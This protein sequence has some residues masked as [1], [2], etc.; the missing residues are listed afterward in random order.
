[1]GLSTT[2]DKVAA[3]KALEFPRNIAEL[4]STIGFFSYY[5]KFVPFFAGI[6]APLEKLKTIGLAGALFKGRKRSNFTA[7]TII[8][9]P[10]PEP[11]VEESADKS[12]KTKRVER[13]RELPPPD[14]LP[15]CH[16]AFKLLQDRLCSAPTLA[17][18]DFKKPFILYVN[19]SKEY[20]F[21]AAL[22]QVGE[23]GVERPVLYI[24]KALSPA[25]A[26]Y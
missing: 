23:D 6:A 4:E 25:E 14:L 13:K 21:S 26:N 9:L 24:S 10:P 22:H 16:Q 7:L 2:E 20:G 18:P 17:H 1:L 12:K 8:P 15:R 11:I 5:R 19:S 3:V